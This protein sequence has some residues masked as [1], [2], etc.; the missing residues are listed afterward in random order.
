MHIEVAGRQQQ[1]QAGDWV[2]VGKQLAL[3]WIADGKVISPFP[4]SVTVEEPEGTSGL[5]IFGHSDDAPE[6]GI[7][8]SDDG[9]WEL[10]WHKTGFWSS[11][12]PVNAAMFAVGFG[13]IT[14]WEI[15]VPLWDYRHLARDEQM[16][17]DE[18]AYTQR[19]I[20]DL[21][22]PLYDI[23]LMFV[24]RCENTRRLFEVWEGESERTRLSFLRSLYRVKPL[25]L[26]L[27]A[28]WTGQW[29]PTTA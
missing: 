10:R 21:R 15:A 4:E 19:I 2:R 28:S 17:D 26:A 16:D 13:L 5:M 27:P 7:D 8:V 23:R 12:A 20:R 25:V 1:Y 18:R 14:N 24:R 6:L 29:V 3:Q 22:V 9:L 11:D